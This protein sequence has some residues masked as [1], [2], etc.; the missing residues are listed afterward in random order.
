MDR[1]L[2]FNKDWS[3]DF[4]AQTDVQFI[5]ENQTLEV[6]SFMMW[7]SPVLYPAVKD[8]PNTGSTRIES[9]FK[10]ITVHEMDHLLSEIYPTSTVGNL[11]TVEK[12]LNM[13]SLSLRLGFKIVYIKALNTLQTME[14]D[15]W[16]WLRQQEPPQ[17]EA[18]VYLAMGPDAGFMREVLVKFFEN[19][20]EIYIFGADPKWATVCAILGKDGMKA[21]QG[22]L[23]N[24]WRNQGGKY[25]KCTNPWL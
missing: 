12:C 16:T 9:A 1:G 2:Q 14:K 10:G 24:S 6:H 17:L 7:Q 5:V 3:E 25:V 22:Y 23:V 8:F 4:A 15:L 19:H 13:L 21:I 18:W 11:N 20:Y